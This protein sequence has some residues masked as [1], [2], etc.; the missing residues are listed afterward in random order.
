VTRHEVLSCVERSESTEEDQ[1]WDE[2]EIVACL[3]CEHVS[4]RQSWFSSE[5]F[6][7]DDSGEPGFAEHA[8]IFPPRRAGRRR[9]K[10][11]YD[12]PAL[13][14]GIYHEVHLA[15]SNNQRI[16]AGIGIRALVEA[17]CA[18]KRAM[19]S[20]L[21]QRIDD[22]ATKKVLTEEAAKVLHAT[23][24]LGNRAAHE[25]VPPNDEQLEAA[26]DI[27]EQLLMNVFVLPKTGQRLA[28]PAEYPDS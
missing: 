1:Y 10:R 22:L 5:E 24:I 3:G 20:N 2:Y 27:A 9:L 14:R 12:L 8:E 13:V 7:L 28:P 6:H 15:I 16:L 17:V 26:M 25:V 11:A 19:G 23:R 18:E 21:E 4:F